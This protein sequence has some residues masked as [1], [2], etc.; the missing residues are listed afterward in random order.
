MARYTSIFKLAIPIAQLHDAI[1]RVLKSC[2][3]NVL[4]NTADY[5][6]AKEIPGGVP[7]AKL[8]IVELLIDRSTAT[9]EAVSFKCVVKNEELPLQVN[10]HCHTISDQVTKA[11]CETEL[12]K[13]LETVESIR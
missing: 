13:V 2:N 6:M 12:W 3:F 9:D 5:V 7:F 11:F 4:H 1:D 8:V 10:N